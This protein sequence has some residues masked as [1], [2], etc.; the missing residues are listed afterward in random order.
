MTENNAA[1][2]V[3][4]EIEAIMEQAQ[5]FASAWAFLGGPFDNGS[6]LEQAERERAALRALLSK[7]RAE[8]VQA[9]DE[10]AVRIP[11]PFSV[12]TTHKNQAFVTLGFYDEDSRKAFVRAVC[13]GGFRVPTDAL[14]SAP[15]A[16][17]AQTEGKYRRMFMAACEALAAINEKLGLDPNDGEPDAIL[18]AIGELMDRANDAAP[19]AS[20]AVRILFPAHLRKMWSGGEVQAWLDEYQGLPS[21]QPSAKGS[22]ERYRQWQ[23]DQTQTDKDGGDCAKGAGD[24]RAWQRL[25]DSERDGFV[26]ELVD[27]GTDFVSPLYAVVESI[28]RRLCEKNA[29][30]SVVK[31]SLTATQTGEKGEKDAQ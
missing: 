23:A 28:E 6:G 5:V 11:V 2:A 16:G 27:Y 1:Q 21:V 7:L 13:H 4:Q 10:R 3:D 14:A 26:G 15:V 8:G 25:T 19:Q 18:S 20:E 17:E 9:G 12:D 24:E 31:Q 29:T 30:P 22:L